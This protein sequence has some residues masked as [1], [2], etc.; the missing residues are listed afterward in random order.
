[1]IITARID[2]SDRGQIRDGQ[3]V[4]VRIDAIPD[5][6]FNG[7]IS[8]ISTI[9]SIDFSG[10]WPY[11]KNFSMKVSLDK[12]DP[13]LR[14]GMSTTLRVAMDRVPNALTIP[15]GALFHE[16]GQNVVYVLNG[17]KFEERFVEVTHQSNDQVLI[18][19]GLQAGDRVALQKPPMKE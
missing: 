9:A 6:E 1:L 4:S 14:P 18:A 8:E 16:E 5:Q 19:K 15:A 7:H 2:E 11:P 17:P 13:R 12:T 10:S 3:P